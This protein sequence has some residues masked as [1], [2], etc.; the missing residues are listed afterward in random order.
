MQGL[1]N[2]QADHPVIGQVRGKGMMIGVELIED[3]QTKKPAKEFVNQMLQQAYHN[4]ILL[5]SCGTSTLR[6]M[7]PLMTDKAIAD[8]ALALIEKT[9]RDVEQLLG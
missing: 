7:P 8:E 9:F 4:G 6:L 5:L 3:P 1:R 2:M